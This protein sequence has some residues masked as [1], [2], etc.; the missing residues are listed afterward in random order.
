[1]P[2]TD[3]QVAELKHAYQVLGVPL[4]ATPIAIKQSYR[5]LIKRWHP[6]YYAAGTQEQADAT[7]MTQT[8]NES[9]ALIQD[10][11]LRYYHG[12]FHP[13]YVAARSGVKDRGYPKVDSIFRFSWFEFWVR[14]IGG[15]IWG[16]MFGFRV[17][18]SCY[19]N[20]HAFMACIIF[21]T[22]AWAFIVTFAGDKFWQEFFGRWWLWR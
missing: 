18:L 19:S 13:D 21:S 8:I 12:A 15:A 17:G 10:A 3:E 14:L 4:S 2:F 7:Q 6:D 20:D 9:Y 22:I 5:E 16:A 11:P 1:V